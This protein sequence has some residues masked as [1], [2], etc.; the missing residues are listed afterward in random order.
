MMRVL[1][2]IA[3]IGGFA[4][5][6]SA[7]VMDFR[8]GFT[9]SAPPL[10]AGAYTTGISY[11]RVSQATTNFGGANSIIAGTTAPGAAS[12]GLRALFSFNLSALPSDAV[13]SSVS[14]RLVSSAGDST[15]AAGKT[16][17]DI[18]RLTRSFVEGTQSTNNQANTS[19]ATWNTFNF[20]SANSSNAT[21]QP[22]SWTTPGGD[23]DST[24]LASLDIDLTAVAT[25]NVHTYAGGTGSADPFVMAANTALAGT[26]V[27]Y[28]MLKEHDEN[29]SGRRILFYNSDDATTPANRPLLEITYTPEPGSMGLLAAAAGAGL[30]RRR[31]RAR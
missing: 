28:L 12:N 22:N 3:A 19:G 16:Q 9:P 26:D 5:L 11:V 18:V 10:T 25:G 8:E 13:I 30:L 14:L 7:D 17:F 24:V 29:S 31:R 23:F 4:G 20:D 21:G 2:F 6:A 1:V 27:L 15:S